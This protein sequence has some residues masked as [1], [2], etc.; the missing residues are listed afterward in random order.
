MAIGREWAPC[1]VNLKLVEVF[2]MDV[3]ELLAAREHHRDE[4]RFIE[5]ELLRY[6]RMY[7]GSVE[8]AIAEGLVKPAFPTPPGYMRH[9]R[10]SK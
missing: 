3:K 6:L 9:L 10:E 7:Q 2:V 5:T 8:E 1:V 4:I